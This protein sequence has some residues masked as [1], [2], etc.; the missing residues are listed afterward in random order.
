MHTVISKSANK[1]RSSPN[2]VPLPSSSAKLSALCQCLKPFSLNGGISC[3]GMWENIPP[4]Q[5]HGS[6][7]YA[8]SR[9]SS[10][11]GSQ[12]PGAQLR[13]L[14]LMFPSFQLHLFQPSL[15][16]ALISCHPAL[17]VFPV[18]GPFESWHI[19]ASVSVFMY[20]CFLYFYSGL[21]QMHV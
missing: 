12:W 8:K 19:C 16:S 17:H 14:V 18:A 21:V 15:T 9:L 11:G 10:S 5:L 1:Y 13:H 2:N 6:T 4:V 7:I 3:G 20:V